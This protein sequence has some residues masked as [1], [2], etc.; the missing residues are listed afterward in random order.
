MILKRKHI[1]FLRWFIVRPRTSGVLSFLFLCA[2]TIIITIQQYQ[3][4]KEQEQR[5]M[6]NILNVVHQNIDQSLKNY[7]TATLTLA[8][9]INDEGIPKNFEYVSKRLIESNKSIFCVQL[10]P[11]GVIKYVYPL[12]ENKPAL[13]LN[14]L[15][16]PY[17][18]KEAFKSIADKKIY[19]AGPLQLKQGGLGIVGR[20]PIYRHN[21]FWGFSAVI[22]KLNTFLA[23]SGIQNIDNSKYYF[24]FSKYDSDKK[25]EKFY[26]NYST[27]LKS[28]YYISTEILDG[29]W[30]LYLISKNK[31]YLYSA[32]LIP[33]ILGFILA[34]ILGLLVTTL[35]KI[36]NELQSLVKLQANKILDTEMKFKTIF[37]QAALGIASIEPVTGNF[38]E[39]NSKFCEMLGY[40]EKEMK[41]KNFQSITH[42][43]DLEQDITN[44]DHLKNGRINEYAMQK[45]YFTKKGDILWVNLTVTPLLDTNQNRENLIAIVEDITLKKTTEKIIKKSETR[46]KSLFDDSPLPLRE[47]DFSEVKKYLEQK[48]LIHK[49]TETVLEY[50]NQN[51]NDVDECHSLIKVI[52]ANKAC[53]KLYKVK[54]I[55]E[56][57]SNKNELFNLKSRNDFINN[58]VAITQGKKQFII[59]TLIRNGKGEFR[60]INLRWNL[61]QG[62]KNTFERVIVS[63]EDITNRLESERIIIDTKQNVESLINT[64]DGIVWEC[65]A[66][67]YN[68]GFISDKVTNILGYTPEEWVNDPHFWSNHIY[69]EDKEW[70]QSY[71]KIKVNE[72]LDH[73]FEYR[74]IAKDGKIVW[75]RDIV[76]IIYDHG[77]PNML[78][79]IMIDITHSK[80]AENELNTSFEIVSEQN[81]RLLNFSYIVSHNLRSHTSNIASIVSFLENT[82]SQEEKNEMLQLLKTVSNS[83]NETMLHLNEV[84]NIRTNISLV[85]VPLNLNEYISTALNVLTEQISKNDI[86]ILSHV[87]LDTIINYNPAYLESILYNIISNSIRYRHPDR[88]AIIKI[89]YH[90]EN[91]LKFLEI[92]DNG[93]GIDLIKNADKL[94]GMYKTFTTN[95]ES[96]GIGLFITKNQIDAMGGTITVESEPNIGTTFKIY[97]R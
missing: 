23:T 34:G 91:N 58:L 62:Y 77:K 97:I 18:K 36:P 14:I 42:P 5:E 66:T 44:V 7:Y 53:L 43:D 8:L 80:E 64:I 49:S 51:P 57:I 19:F 35:L 75:L 96:K 90:I 59:D 10:V 52:N 31:Y 22:V 15:T 20:Y 37:D 47:E 83:L 41:L 28:K 95:S 2:V 6:N 40:T 54:N 26:L 87:P 55:D 45:R 93:I 60:A 68:F 21:T 69:P 84:I 1:K 71:C 72:N 17:L 61:V 79:G 33:C 29:D 38:L 78:R 73:D 63:T 92:S 46:F 9:T 88:T 4:V 67:T 30:K 27:D 48:K 89:S 13:N 32:I 85:L 81:K 39:I 16:N 70:V 76:N 56:L 12:A 24:Q 94:F 3:L 11:Q 86:S 65:D 82:D 25:K 74:M 50:F